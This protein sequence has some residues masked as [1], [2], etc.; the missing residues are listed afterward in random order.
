MH[1]YFRH[2]T[3]LKGFLLGA[4]LLGG[5]LAP[6]IHEAQHGLEWAEI[7][8]TYAGCAH[9]THGANFDDHHS[10][11]SLDICPFCYHRWDAFFAQPP[12]RTFETHET[13]FAWRKVWVRDVLPFSYGARAP[14][15]HT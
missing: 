8:A 14:P 3:W 4:F 9:S 7:N 2:I 5:V 6:V 15:R 1:R 10:V 13:A 12:P 11:I